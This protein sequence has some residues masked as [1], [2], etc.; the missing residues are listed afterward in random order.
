MYCVIELIRGKKLSTKALA[1]GQIFGL[2]VLSGIMLLA[3]YNNI[4]RILP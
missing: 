3:L 4:L 2:V 1:V